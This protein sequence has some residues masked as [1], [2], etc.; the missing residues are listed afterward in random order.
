MNVL[1]LFTGCGGGL[2]AQSLLG[3][4]TVCACEID[5]HCRR[6]IQARQNEGHL[7]PFPIWD[8]IRTFDGRPWR[9]LVDCVFAGF[10]CQPFSVA[11]RRRGAADE[12]NLWPAT[13]RVLGE[14]QPAFALLENVPGLLGKHGY[15][16]EILRDLAGIGFDAEWD[17]FSAAAL[18]APHLRKRLFVLAHTQRAELQL[19]S[20]RS[21]RQDGTGEAQPE[22]HGPA[23]AVADA[24]GQRE[25]QPGG[26]VREKRRWAPNSGETLADAQRPGPQ[27]REEPQ[28]LEERQTPLGNRWWTAEPAVGRV[29]DGFS[30][31]VGELHALG[32]AVVPAVA[33][34]AW[35][36]LRA[37]AE[38][39]RE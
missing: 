26:T 22:D 28:L 9:G 33:A 13:F 14:V 1:D 24:N 10:P 39:R 2:L 19:E 6:V 16:G 30:G 21:S 37:R 36:T 11:G 7:P 31:R 27:K 29:V 23:G 25:L 8:D 5:P 34:T 38:A 17:V 3:F 15:F 12:R 4:R 32:N 18:G 20:G 35:R